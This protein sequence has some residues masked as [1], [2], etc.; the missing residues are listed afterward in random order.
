[1]D[2][3]KREHSPAEHHAAWRTRVLT[4]VYALAALAAL[5]VRAEVASIL[6]PIAGPWAGHLYGHADCT[7]ASALPITSLVVALLFPLALATALIWR[8]MI[9]AAIPLVVWSAAWSALAWLS[10]VNST[11]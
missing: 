1:M 5:S 10:A 2:R 7:M 6:A 11:E 4:G 3:M 8:R 9:L